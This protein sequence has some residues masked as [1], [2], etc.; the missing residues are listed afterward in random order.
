MLSEF[1]IKRPRYTI[2]M[3]TYNTKKTIERCFESL[4]YQIDDRFEIIVV[5]N[6]SS[7]DSEKYLEK[8]AREGRISLI[9]RECTCGLDRQIAAETL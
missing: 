7:D 9:R 2:C 6:L 4:L 3:T 5:D 1:Y 8:L